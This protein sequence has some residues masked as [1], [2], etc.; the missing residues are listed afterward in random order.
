[1]YVDLPLWIH[2]WWAAKRQFP[3]LFRPRPNFVPGCP[4][5]PKTWALAKMMWWIHDR[6]RW[7]RGPSKREP[8]RALSRWGF[9]MAV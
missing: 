7:D 4:M 1:V 9:R 8:T 2:Y 3:C 6:H 5:L